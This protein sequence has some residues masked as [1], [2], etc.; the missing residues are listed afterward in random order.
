MTTVQGGDL[1][2]RRGGAGGGGGVGEGPGRAEEGGWTCTRASGASCSLGAADSK[3]FPRLAVHI[4]KAFRE[5]SPSPGL[6][7]SGGWLVFGA[8]RVAVACGRQRLAA[9]T[10]GLVQV[11]AIS[12]TLPTGSFPG[13]S[14]GQRPQ[15]D[16]LVAFFCLKTKNTHCIQI[17]KV[18]LPPHPL[19]SLGKE[20]ETEK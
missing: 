11:W 18:A 15:V 12:G 14:S 16:Y 4:C 13:L 8:R 3:C 2:A 6:R 7:E 1:G 5:R 19:S 9:S 17:T 10:A 20:K